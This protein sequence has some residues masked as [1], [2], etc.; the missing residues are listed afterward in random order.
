MNMLR[1]QIA[2]RQRSRSC[3]RSDADLGLWIFGRRSKVKRFL[4]EMPST[5]RLSVSK[6]FQC[7]S[8]VSHSEE[9]CLDT[10]LNAIGLKPRILGLPILYNF[11]EHFRSGLTKLNYMAR[12]NTPPVRIFQLRPAKFCWEKIEFFSRPQ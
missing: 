6:K 10:H 7:I 3:S 2:T 1:E 5:F 12:E 11:M 8:G 9:G 4:C